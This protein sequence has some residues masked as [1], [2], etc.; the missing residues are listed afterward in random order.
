VAET[1]STKYLRV[2]LLLV[3]VIFMVGIYPLT[4]IWPS[5]WSWHPGQSDYLQMILGI[6][7]TLGV[8]L[9][10]CF[11]QPAR[12]LEP[13]LVHGVVQH[14]ARRNHGSAIFGELRAHRTPLGRRPGAICCCGCPRTPDATRCGSKSR[15][16]KG[17]T[18][19]IPCR[20]VWNN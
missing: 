11:A 2:A 15:L 20:Q 9:L 10:V 17:Q 6:Y 18:T 7:A 3:G 5:G 13:H 16:S 14:C 19:E 8:F 4:I 12:T 1:D